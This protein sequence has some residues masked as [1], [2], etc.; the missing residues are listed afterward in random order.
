MLCRACSGVAG[1][2]K[3]GP[4]QQAFRAVV[5]WLVRLYYPV[6]AVVGRERLPHGPTLF[7]LNHPNAL[8]DPMVLWTAL[9]RPLRFLAKSTLFENP[10]GHFAMSA[11]GAI[12]VFRKRDLAAGEGDP[13]R[14]DETFARCRAALARGDAVALFPEGTSH[15]A[16]SMKPLKTGAAR[17]ALSAIAEQPELKLSLVPVGLGYE[18]KAVFRSRAHV[19]LGDPIAIADLSARYATDPEAAV[20]SLTERIRAGLDAVVLQADTRELLDG[21]A[22]IAALTDPAL[23]DDLA[24]RHERAKAM[25]RAYTELAQRDPARADAMVREARRYVRVLGALGIVDPW[26]LEVERLGFRRSLRHVLELVLLGPAA[27]AGA[28][29]GWVPYRLA[30]KLA[31]HFFDEEDV[32]GTVKLLMGAVFLLAS[33]SLEA[34]LAAW[35]FAWPWG[36]VVLVAGPAAG[37]AALHFGDRVE[38][39]RAALQ[40]LVLRERHPDVLRALRERRQHL[41]DLVAE[42]LENHGQGPARPA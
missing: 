41:A 32:R 15:S 23:R 19:R 5:F 18:D 14:N 26:A 8:L 6:R 34:A 3:L 2:D 17:I 21:V 28:L 9:G 33:W 20:H 10:V 36:L 16:P 37:Y 38:I 39:T 35:W 30:G 42:G 24:A 29:L 22:R 40:Y 25:L 11:F 12:P 1:H 27:V 4:V 31:R 7:V 13:S